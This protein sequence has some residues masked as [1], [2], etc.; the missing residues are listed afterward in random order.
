[1]NYDDANVIVQSKFPN[2]LSKL[3]LG[4]FLE[5]LPVSNFNRTGLVATFSK[6]SSQLN[7][8]LPNVKV[9]L[10]DT[11]FKTE[12]VI[13]VQQLTF[14]RSIKLFEK[15][16][17][18]L[19]GRINQITNWENIAIEVQ[20]MFLNNPDNVPKLLCYKISNYIDILYNRSQVEISNSEVVYNRAVSQFIKANTTY[21]KYKINKNQSRE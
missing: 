13:N 21:N 10:F 6:D 17:V 16:R 5:L 1:M 15:Y 4:H 11:A 8:V 14:S 19:S 9:M 2:F 18:K 20:G 3:S 7:A 12:A